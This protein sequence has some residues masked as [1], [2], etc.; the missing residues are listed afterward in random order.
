MICQASEH[1]LG[2]L[3]KPLPHHVVELVAHMES[4]PAAFCLHVAKA[5]SGEGRETRL[6][7]GAGV[8]PGCTIYD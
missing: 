4:I 5:V 6:F 7:K 1:G 2:L 8:C 3:T